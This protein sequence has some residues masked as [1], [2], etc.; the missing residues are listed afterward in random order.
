MCTSSKFTTEGKTRRPV[1]GPSEEEMK[2]G[3]ASAFVIRWP[4]YGLLGPRALQA[5]RSCA[6]V[7]GLLREP[8]SPWP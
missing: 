4:A 2:K 6:P 3:L 5:E 1:P 8:L 7:S